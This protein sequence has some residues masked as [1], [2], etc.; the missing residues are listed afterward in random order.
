MRFWFIPALLL[1]LGLPAPSAQA[2]IW[3]YFIIQDA[4]KDLDKSV[5]NSVGIKVEE[6]AF[7]HPHTKTKITT[8]SLGKC[9]EESIWAFWENYWEVDAGK[10]FPELTLDMRVRFKLTP[11]SAPARKIKIRW[12]PLGITQHIKANKFLAKTTELYVVSQ[13]WIQNSFI[14]EAQEEI[15]YVEIGQSGN[16]LS[17][18]GLKF[19]D[20][21]SIRVEPK[22]EFKKWLGI[23]YADVVGTTAEALIFDRSL[24]LTAP[25]Y[26]IS[27]KSNWHVGMGETPIKLDVKL[28]DTEA[29][30]HFKEGNS[31]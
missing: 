14:M 21:I 19:I 23:E 2:D 18:T 11:E 30:K 8:T 29:N 22:Y 28:K 25:L 20:T 12:T 6:C 10:S 9:L 13:S 15:P 31:K 4:F 16:V 17:A 26:V 27:V 1:T 24:N 3:K 5:Q 7:E